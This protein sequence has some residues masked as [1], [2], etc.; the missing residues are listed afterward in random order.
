ML[1]QMRPI[2][3]YNE[4][5]TIYTAQLPIKIN[6]TRFNN[7]VGLIVSRNDLNNSSYNKLNTTTNEKYPLRDKQ[8]Q[9]ITKRV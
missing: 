6:N 5:K 3:D 2:I 7:I 8:P 9:K 1:S 4:N